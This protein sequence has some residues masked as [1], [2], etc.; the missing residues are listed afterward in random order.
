VRVLPHQL[1]VDVRGELHVAG[2]DLE[3]LEAALCRI[4]WWG[5]DE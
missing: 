5:V 3:D 1:Q 4:V 2:L